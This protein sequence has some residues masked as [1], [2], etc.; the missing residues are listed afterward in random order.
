MKRQICFQS[1]IVYLWHVAGRVRTCPSGYEPGDGH[2]CLCRRNTLRFRTRSA[3]RYTIC[4]LKVVIMG[5]VKYQQLPTF[6][7]K[8]GNDRIN[9]VFPRAAELTLPMGLAQVLSSIAP[10]AWTATP[11]RARTCARVAGARDPETGYRVPPCLSRAPRRTASAPAR[12]RGTAISP[13]WG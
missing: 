9:T 6:N 3:R 5:D 10:A 1:H 13:P 2:A 4:R 11:W 7:L 12:S 8:R